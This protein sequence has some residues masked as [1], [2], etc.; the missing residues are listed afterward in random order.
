MRRASTKYWTLVR[1]AT[2]VTYFA[3]QITNIFDDQLQSLS[4]STVLLFVLAFVAKSSKDRVD[5]VGVAVV[6]VSVGLAE[7]AVSNVLTIQLSSN[8][9][10]LRAKILNRKVD[11]IENINKCCRSKVSIISDKMS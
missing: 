11:D 3:C 9:S 8:G 1:V 10:E 5:D 7:E 6:K 2:V 4:P